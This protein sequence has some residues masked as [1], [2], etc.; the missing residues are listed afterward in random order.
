MRV[1]TMP[2][3]LHIRPT[4]QRGRIAL[5]IE[6]LEDRS[7]PS[8][9]VRLTANVGQFYRPVSVIA[10]GPAVATALT[11]LSP[12]DPWAPHQRGPGNQ[13]AGGLLAQ[14]PALAPPVVGPAALAPILNKRRRRS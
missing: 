8:G 10:F 1:L 12:F 5:R 7:L 6:A 4:R 13:F 9:G 3:P 2:S 11:I 14:E